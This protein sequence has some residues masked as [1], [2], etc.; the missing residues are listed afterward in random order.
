MIN[1]VYVFFL[2]GAAGNFL[3]RCLSLAADRCV[4]QISPVSASPYLSQDEKFQLFRYDAA[5]ES[6]WIDFESRLIH[7]SFRFEH[8]ELTPGSVSI[9]NMHPDYD[10]LHRNIAGP[11]DSK[12]VFYI[13]PSEAFEWC[14]LNALYK[15]S[16]I[17]KKWLLQGRQM[18]DDHDITK[19]NLADIFLS[20]ESCILLIEKICNTVHIDLASSHRQKI[21]ELW[22]QWIDTTLKPAEF[23]KFK[24]SIGFNLQNLAPLRGN[25]PRTLSSPSG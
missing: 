9:W 16:H 8:T 22:H 1:Y 3:S 13:D 4:G 17:E 6:N 7:Y 12:F 20:C 24:N 19:I 5:R 2:P 21:I 23:T 15:D 10:F 11:D 14:T 18:L 25:D